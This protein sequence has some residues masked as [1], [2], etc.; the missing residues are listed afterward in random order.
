MRGGVTSLNKTFKIRIYPNKEQIRVING[1]LNSTR[2]LY[3]YMLN[4]KDKLY[5]FF[6]ISLSYNHSSRVMT[7]L[8]KHKTWLK[9]VDSTALQ[10]TLRDLDS[11]YQNF[12]NGRGKY[13]KFKS[14]K[15]SKNSYRTVS[16]TISLNIDN[17]TI[18]IPKVGCVRFRDKSKFDGLTKINNITISKTS[19][20][21][22]YASISAEVNIRYSEK[23]NQNIGID[24]GLKD[25]AILSNGDK[26]DNT[27]YFVNAQKKLARMQHKLSKKIFGSNKYQKYKIKVARFHEKIKN[28]RLDFLHKLS[29]NLV[30]DYDIIC[31]ETL[32]VKN[33]V[34]NHRL[35]KSFQDVSLSEFIRMLEYKAKWYG[36]IISKVDRFY[37]SSQLCSNCGYKNSKVK[38]LNIRE[39]ICPECGVH[40][41]R[42]INSA[43]NILNEG[44][45]IL[46]S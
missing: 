45:R 37:P 42:D 6:G 40:H 38:N 35:A 24:L 22:Y 44:L 36:K 33:M 34:K 13:P 46:N 2:Y 41:D 23:T 16:S 30:K 3:N 17:R 39:W 18:K 31:V 10:Q 8:K 12:F 26:V 11:A 25:F 7:E 21:K 14:K 43:I 15:R 28:Q 20:G 4:L 5:K 29:T 27:R 9:L 32:K 19:S 1:T